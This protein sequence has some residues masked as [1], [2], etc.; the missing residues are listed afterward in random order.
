MTKRGRKPNAV[1]KVDKFTGE[2][3]GRYRSADEA[4]KDN[5]LSLDSVYT[6]LSKRLL[7]KERCTFRYAKD[8]DPHEEFGAKRNR[9]IVCYTLDGEVAGLFPSNEVARAELMVGQTVV[10][11]A[12]VDSWRTIAGMFRLRR[13]ERMGEAL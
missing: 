6:V 10:S 4:A 13:L 11:R 2:L 1:V 3:V 8:Y 7:T 9:P 12:C 5:G